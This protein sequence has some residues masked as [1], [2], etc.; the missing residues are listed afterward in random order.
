MT[1]LTAVREAVEF[2]N[3][4]SGD[5]NVSRVAFSIGDYAVYWYGIMIGLGVLLALIYAMKRSYKMGVLPDQVFDIA[6][7]GAIFGFLGARI[8]Y[9]VFTGGYNIV[10]MF[11]E[12]RDG[13]LAIYG[14]VIAAAIAAVIVCKINGA[15]IGAMFDVGGIGLLIGQ[16]IGRWGNFFNQECFGAPTA[17]D[18]PW[19]MTGSTIVNAPEV[20][21]AQSK[22]PAG[23]YA[24]VHPCF[25]YEFLWCFVGFLILHF[26]I[27]KI[28]TFDGEVFICYVIWYGA[29]RAWIEGLRTD[30]LYIGPL[31]VSQVI[32]LATAVFCLILLVY[33]KI[34]HK[35]KGT[36]VYAKTEEFAE[37]AERYKRDRIVEKEV[38]AAK[39]AAKRTR[40][41][42]VV[43][44]SI[45][46]DDESENRKGN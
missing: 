14:G 5:I 20:I 46:G 21:E 22:L 40:K 15:K 44:P 10:T 4:F 30:S 19:G 31:K 41:E 2:P 3:L 7:W 9:C 34:Y 12:V 29:G 8:Y 28:K 27:S 45:L 39:K 25:L 6:F 42:A 38:E 13:G 11:T 32:A 18:L 16:G 26:I 37:V 36:V 33:L 43:A 35:K 23:E 24:L 1:L 17:N